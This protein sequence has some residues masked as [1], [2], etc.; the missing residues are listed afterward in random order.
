MSETEGVTGE[1]LRRWRELKNLSRAQ[2]LMLLGPKHQDKSTRTIQKIEQNTDRFIPQWLTSGLSDG[3]CR[4]TVIE[5]RMD[6]Y[7]W[8]TGG[9]PSEDVEPVVV[10]DDIVE[11]TPVGIAEVD[12]SG[13]IGQLLRRQGYT[14]SDMQVKRWL[15]GEAP[16]V[17]V[18]TALESIRANLGYLVRAAQAENIISGIFGGSAFGSIVKDE[19]I[20]RKMLSDIDLR[21]AQGEAELELGHELRLP[22]RYTIVLQQMSRVLRL[23][24]VE[25]VNMWL[26]RSLETILQAT[27][28]ST[29]HDELGLLNRQTRRNLFRF[30][31]GQRRMKNASARTRDSH[32]VK[33]GS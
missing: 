26:E 11:N 16:P 15:T 23:S 22:T 9:E 13:F 33:D 30:S 24:M 5:C 6:L 4:R 21:R 7:E 1:Q 12:E 17:D 3:K 31:I 2:V 10:A 32:E 8:A 28:I 18:R 20:E 19:P 29:K 25:F 27:R 14:V